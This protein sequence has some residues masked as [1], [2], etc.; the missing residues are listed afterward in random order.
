VVLR[1]ARVS[2]RLSSPLKIL[3]PLYWLLSQS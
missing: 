1:S 2:A 3:S